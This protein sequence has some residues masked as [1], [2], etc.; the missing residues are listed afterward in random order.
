MINKEKEEKGERYSI[1]VLCGKNNIKIS[2]WDKKG[3]LKF[4][5]NNCIDNSFIVLARDRKYDVELPGL[6]VDQ[7]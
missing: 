3:H 6:A 7:L 1:K 2:P 5:E 4:I